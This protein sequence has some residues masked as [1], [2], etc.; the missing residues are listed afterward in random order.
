MWLRA[1]K[2]MESMVSMYVSS[3]EIREGRDVRVDERICPSSV[4]VVSLNDRVV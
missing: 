2:C 1:S 4:E 3:E